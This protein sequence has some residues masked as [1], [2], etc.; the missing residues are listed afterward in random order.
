MCER[1]VIIRTSR[2]NYH[3][4]TLGV[5][6]PRLPVV[7]SDEVARQTRPNPGKP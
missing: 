3:R 7:N 1:R 6:R 4:P 2:S 5:I